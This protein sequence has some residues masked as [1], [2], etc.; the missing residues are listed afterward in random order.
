MKIFVDGMRKPLERIRK[1]QFVT[2]DAPAETDVPLTLWAQ[3]QSIIPFPV[4]PAEHF[5]LPCW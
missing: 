4:S 3:T 1:L 5:F 2:Y